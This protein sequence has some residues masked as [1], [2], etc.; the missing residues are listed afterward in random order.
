MEEC[1]EWVLYAEYR[2]RAAVHCTPV[3]CGSL[4]IW[5]TIQLE[6]PSAYMASAT[7]FSDNHPGLLCFLMMSYKGIARN[8]AEEAV[9]ALLCLLN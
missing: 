6:L 3:N 5:S 1:E 8:E 2:S 7:G 4:D 9:T